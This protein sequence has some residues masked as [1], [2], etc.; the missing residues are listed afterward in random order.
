MRD[1]D[2]ARDKDTDKAIHTQDRERKL[3]TCGS[4]LGA[5]CPPI[6]KLVRDGLTSLKMRDKDHARDTDTDKEAEIHKQ[7]RLYML[8]NNRGPV[9]T[10]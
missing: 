9:P 6:R 5:R 3:C 8:V 7:E 1:K 2:H 10:D 4:M